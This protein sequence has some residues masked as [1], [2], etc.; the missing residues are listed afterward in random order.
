MEQQRAE[1]TDLSH[2]NVAKPRPEMGVYCLAEVCVMSRF[3]G[4]LGL[5]LV[6]VISVP[7]W[8]QNRGGNRWPTPPPSADQVPVNHGSP[9][10][11]LEQLKQASEQHKL[12]VQSDTTRL[13]E[14]VNQLKQDLEHTP[15]GVL[16]I[17][18]VKKSKEVEKLAKRVRKEMQQD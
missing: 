4:G 1:S 17:G 3:I 10:A 16:S 7:G 11:N 15:A 9:K 8:G 18:A 2:Q 12:Q 13:A 6:L 14:L 5:A